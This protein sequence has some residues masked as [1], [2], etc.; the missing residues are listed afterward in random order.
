MYHR[1]LVWYWDYMYTCSVET[2]ICTYVELNYTLNVPFLIVVVLLL[3]LLWQG[4]RTGGN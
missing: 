1:S 2:Y 4:S 3:L